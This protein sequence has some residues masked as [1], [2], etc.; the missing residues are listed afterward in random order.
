MTLHLLVLPLHVIIVRRPHYPNIPLSLKTQMRPHCPPEQN[1]SKIIKEKKKLLVFGNL[2]WGCSHP[3]SY[4]IHFLTAPSSVF[5]L[6]YKSYESILLKI[7]S[8]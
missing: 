7:T 4:F 5:Q 8:G 1:R 2:G 3:V 6:L